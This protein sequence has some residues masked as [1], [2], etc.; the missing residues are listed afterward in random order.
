MITDPIADM[1]TRVRNAIHAK[2]ERVEVPYSKLKHELCKIL[3]KEGYVRGSD[4]VWDG[5]KGKL[6]LTLRY[7]ASREPVLTSLRRI[8]KP[9]RRVYVASEKIKS[10]L[11]GMGVAVLSTSKGLMTDKQAKEAK[12]GGE[13]L[14]HLW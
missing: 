10:V 5:N 9:G 6:S 13:V 12:L 1:L 4:L 3:E 8:S 11:G 14:C 2:K 7:S